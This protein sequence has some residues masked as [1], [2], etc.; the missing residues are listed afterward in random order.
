[1]IL[2]FER[3][4]SLKLS[5]ARFNRWGDDPVNVVVDD[6]YMRVLRTAA[7]TTPYRVRQLSDER[8]EMDGPAV[9]ESDIRWRLAE[10]LPY[11]PLAELARS[12]TRVAALADEKPGYRPPMEPDPFEGLIQAITAQQVNLQWAVTTRRRLVEAFGTPLDAFGRT[13][14]AFP[15][16]SR[17]AGLEPSDLRALQFTWRKA[18]YIIEV[19]QGAED[20]RLDG[21][22]EA[23]DQDVIRRLTDLRGIGRWSADWIL[24]RSL[25]RPDAVAAGDLGVRK[26]VSHIWS[27]FDEL[28]P[29]GNVREIAALWG[30]AANWVTHLLLEALS[31]S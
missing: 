25:A 26:A 5:T 3:P 28:L 17:L 20:G 10:A 11:E 2:E 23:S 8:L 4:V 31:D 9:A 6:I 16:P 21:L 18:E 29:E 12:D 27:G 14:W 1:M 22:R 19:A 7:G 24:A 15:E 30:D 13:L